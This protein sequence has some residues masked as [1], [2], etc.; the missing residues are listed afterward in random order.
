MPAPANSQ[1]LGREF[2][3]VVD[4]ASVTILDPRGGC[5]SGKPLEQ[6]VTNSNGRLD[7]SVRVEAAL[8]QQPELA[9]VIC[10]FG[11]DKAE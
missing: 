4:A 8:G 2:D 1:K 10:E 7:C 5:V 11:R 3:R 6:I 9:L